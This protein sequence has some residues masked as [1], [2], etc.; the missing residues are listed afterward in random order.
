MRIRSLI[1]AT[2]VI[3]VVVNLAVVPVSLELPITTIETHQLSNSTPNGRCQWPS[4][5]I[6]TCA[7]YP[8][9]DTFVDNLLPSETMQSELGGVIIV[10]DTPSVPTSKNYGYLRFDFNAVFPSGIITAHAKPMNASLWLYNLYT[11]A[12]R[13]ASV[14]AYSVTNH[15]WTEQTLTWNNMPEPDLGHYTTQRISLDDRWYSWNV[16][17]E[18]QN[19]TGNGIVCFSLMAGFRSP[20]NYAMF[21]SKDNQN[22]AEWPELDISFKGP[23][24]RIETLPNL[25]ITIDGTQMITDLKGELQTFLLWGDHNVSVA[26]FLP[27]SEG[28][29]MTF[30]KWSDGLT[31]PIRQVSIGNNLTL[32]ASYQPQYRLDVNSPYALPSGSGWYFQNETATASV[33]PTIVPA[34]GILGLVGV[35]HVLDHWTGHCKTQSVTCSV[36][37]NGPYT[38]TAVWR[39]DYTNT[40]LLLGSIAVIVGIIV[41][42][43]NRRRR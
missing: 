36:L 40:I 5:S 33:E 25:P 30:V 20:A 26:G 22:T 21:A 4:S 3:L 27:V 42:V 10:Q 17:A 39:D 29:R 37:M 32:N 18:V 34:E 9:D 15:N 24:L 19:M 2:I 13:N 14:S 8:T 35:R 38:V 11:V 31:S 1:D 6:I 41:L 7:V 23:A 12:L 43:Y 16:T 28:M